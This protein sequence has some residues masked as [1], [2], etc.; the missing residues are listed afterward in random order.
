LSDEETKTVVSYGN[1]FIVPQHPELQ[2]EL[3]DRA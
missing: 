1:A 2:G 3:G